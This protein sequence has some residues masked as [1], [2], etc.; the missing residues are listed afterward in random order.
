M[1]LGG[2]GGVRRP[3]VASNCA[4]LGLILAKP[5][6]EARDKAKLTQWRFVEDVPI[7]STRYPV[8]NFL[9]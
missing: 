1:G 6:L 5:T 7:I 8:D 2:Y 3:P 9:Q 4:Q